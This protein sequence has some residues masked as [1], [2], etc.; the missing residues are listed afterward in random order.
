MKLEITKQ[1]T[2]PE[3][4]VIRLFLTT[5]PNRIY[6]KAKEPNGDEWF[7]LAIHE[8]G[9]FERCSGLLEPDFRVDK[10]LKIIEETKED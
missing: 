2:E 5:G 8:D 3:E 10:E 9:T 1:K 6:L 4:R 7:V